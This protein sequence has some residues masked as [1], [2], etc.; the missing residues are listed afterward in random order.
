M[1]VE[2]ILFFGD[3][4]YGTLN[5]AGLAFWFTDKIGFSLETTYKNHLEIEKIM[6]LLMLH[7]IFNTLQVLL[8][9]L[10][11]K[12]LMMEYMIKMMRPEVAGLKEFNGCP[13]TDGDGIQDSA[14][15]CPDVFGLAT[16]NGC[17]DTDGDGVADV[18]DACP[19]V[20]GLASLKGCPD[21]DKDGVADK[22]DVL[23]QDQKKMQ[24]VLS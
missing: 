3:S 8:S 12:I 11:E 24:V 21:T 14:D 15:A 22:D 16:L 17:P 9:N 10:E 2:V 18:N 6:E 23:L 19:D 7:L 5:G 4:S 20:F 1:L 13:D